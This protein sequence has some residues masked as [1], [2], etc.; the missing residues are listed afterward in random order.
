MNIGQEQVDG[1]KG[2]HSWRDTQVRIV[3]EAAA[4]LQAVFMIDWYNAVKENIFSGAYYPLHATEPIDGAVPVQI[5]TSGPDSQWA[6]IRQLY[7]FMIGSAQT[8]VYIQSPFFI[9]DATI[10]EALKVAALAEVDVRVMLSAR[11]SGNRLPQWAGNT[12]VADIAAA[13]VRVFL[14]EKGY[15]H[16]KTI[17]VDGR[18]CSIGSANID[19]RSF[20]INYELNAILYSERL[21]RQLEEDFDRDLTFCTEFQPSAYVKCPAAARFRDS[22]ARLLSPLL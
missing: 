18:A 22:V 13:G 9:P 6:A 11:P 10:A 19:I 14:Y 17:S 16:A 3:G 1:G 8:H 12:Y 15:L 4:V 2:F 7:V 21:A 20:S 5:L